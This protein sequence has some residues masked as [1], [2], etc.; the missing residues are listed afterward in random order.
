MAQIK[1]LTDC[2]L[3]P[4]FLSGFNRV[5][6]WK[7]QW[8]KTDNVWVLAD[9][10][11]KQE[12]SDEKRKW[13]PQYLRWHIEHGGAVL[14]AY[15]SDKLIGF[16]SLDGGTQLINNYCYANLTMLFVDDR[17]QRRGTGTLLF[18]KIKEIATNQKAEKIFISAIPSEA[19]VAFYSALGCVDAEVV[20]PDFI[21][22]ESDRYL[23]INIK[24]GGS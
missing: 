13:I 23:E 21:D 18:N 1:E 24:Q 6:V 17:Y 14:G 9:A 5:Q 2:E 8:V 11:G 20:I 16:A 22:T 12:W 3:T 19:T 10:D 7:R 4:D 15:E